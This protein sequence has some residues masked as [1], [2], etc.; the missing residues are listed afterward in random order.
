MVL[1]GQHC[2][3]LSSYQPNTCPLYLR[4]HYTLHHEYSTPFRKEQ[5]SDNQAYTISYYLLRLQFQSG[6]APLALQH[7]HCLLKVLPFKPI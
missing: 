6:A 7:L 3:R 1:L 5:H 2:Q 4:Q